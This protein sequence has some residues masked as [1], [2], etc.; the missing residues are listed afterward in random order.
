MIEKNLASF[1]KKEWRLQFLKINEAVGVTVIFTP[2]AKRKEQ[3]AKT[4]LEVVIRTSVD[5]V[6]NLPL[7]DAGK[8]LGNSSHSWSANS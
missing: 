1:Y 3:S 8:T 7:A 6:K 2:L 4:T 5:T